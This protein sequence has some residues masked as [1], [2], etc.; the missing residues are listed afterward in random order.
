[1]KTVNAIR[2]T[3][4]T[5]PPEVQKWLFAERLIREICTTYGYEEIRTPMSNRPN[6]SPAALGK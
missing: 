1:M 2:G 5:Y 4:D 6:C 3:R